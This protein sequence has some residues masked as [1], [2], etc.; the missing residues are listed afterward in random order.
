MILRLFQPS[1]F[2]SV[3]LIGISLTSLA[4][5]EKSG[6]LFESKIVPI[7]EANCLECHNSNVSKGNLSLTSLKEALQGGEEGTGLVPSHPDKSRIVQ[8]I[9]RSDPDMPKKK[10]ALSATD[11]EL[12]RQW[13]ASGAKWPDSVVLREKSKGDKSWWAYTALSK[14]K[15]PSPRYLLDRG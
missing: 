8:Y 5:D 14:E 10:D 7:L 12:I 15:P 13:I 1:L 6:S 4:A 9:T 2:V 3:I 11:V